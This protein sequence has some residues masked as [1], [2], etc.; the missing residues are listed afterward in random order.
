M[1]IRP[2]E[3]SAVVDFTVALFRA[4]GYT[5][6]GRIA[7]TRKKIPLLICGERRDTKTVVCI[8][9]DNDEILLL[10]QEDKRHMEGSDPEPQLIAQAI[11]AFTANNQTRVRTLRLPPLQSKVIPGITL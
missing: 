9:D 10:V 2:D 4:C 5:G 3:E 7:R 8:M 1:T 11:A 6:V